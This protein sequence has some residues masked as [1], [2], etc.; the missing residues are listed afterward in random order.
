MTVRLMNRVTLIAMTALG[1]ASCSSAGE[2]PTS[3]SPAENVLPKDLTASA[4]PQCQ[5][6]YTLDCQVCGPDDG[7]T[8]IERVCTCDPTPLPTFSAAREYAVQPGWARA[9]F[10]YSGTSAAPLSGS[11]T[12][13]AGTST[14]SVA[15]STTVLSSSLVAVDIRANLG[16]LAANGLPTP[17]EVTSVSIEAAGG[18]RVSVGT[19]SNA[20]ATDVPVGY[21]TPAQLVGPITGTSVSLQP[22][23]AS[24]R[25]FAYPPLILAIRSAEGRIAFAEVEELPARGSVGV[26]AMASFIGGALDR[27]LGGGAEIYPAWGLDVDLLGVTKVTSGTEESNPGHNFYTSPAASSPSLYFGDPG[28]EVYPAPPEYSQQ[29]YLTNVLDNRAV[30]RCPNA[31]GCLDVV[32]DANAHVLNAVSGATVAWLEGGPIQAGTTAA[33]QLVTLSSSTSP[34]AVA[35]ASAPLPV[36]LAG[37]AVVGR[38]APR[39]TPSP[40]QEAISAS[41]S[42]FSGTV[43]GGATSSCPLSGSTS[44]VPLTPCTGYR[45]SFSCPTVADPL[46]VDTL[47][48]PNPPNMGNQVSLSSMMPQYA[49]RTNYEGTCGSHAA[50]QYYELLVN[51]LGADM[52]LQ[53]FAPSRAVMVDGQAIAVPNPLIAYS[54]TGGVADLYNW[55]GTMAGDPDLGPAPWPTSGH[56]LP[57]YINGYWPAYEGDWQWW[58]SLTVSDPRGAAALARC[59]SKGYWFSG[60]CVGEGQP[61]PGAYWNYN[62]QLATLNQNPFDAMP[63]SLAN[64]YFDTTSNNLSLSDPSAAIQEVMS[65]VSNGLPVLMGFDAGSANITDSAGTVPN[66]LGD[67]SWFLPPELGSCDAATLSRAFQPSDPHDVDIIGYSLVG[68]VSA[69]DIFQSYFII[70]NNW[71]KDQG[72]GGFFAMNFA[73]FKYR[74]GSLTTDHLLCGYNSLVCPPR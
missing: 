13:A 67:M 28:G 71:G 17:C 26:R 30:P 11:V 15:V 72:Y 5:P 22:P 54:V 59:A 66:L 60:Y 56:I 36:S 61:P 37:A 38:P 73:A 4:T 16:W 50:T 20:F 19:F 70:E 32:Y 12:C 55:G 57:Q 31:N 43:M 2:A 6:G 64:T 23:A 62:N 48:G 8:K 52:T 53:S 51:K 34:A 74:A 9:T 58:T 63:W 7:C 35:A 10:N 1:S 44:S 33:P 69:P 49:G 18:S 65:Y 41:L 45:E 40:Q 46:R 39:A 14:S 27:E 24:R 68:S 42:S 29:V 25:Y 3:G 21:R 47:P